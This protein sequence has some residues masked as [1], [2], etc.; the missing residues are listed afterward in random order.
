M[1]NFLL[2]YQNLQTNKLENKKIIYFLNNNLHFSLSFEEGEKLSEK[3]KD[4]EVCLSFLMSKKQAVLNLNEM[5]K[6][7]QDKSKHLFYLQV[8]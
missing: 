4:E 6:R 1:K 2:C 5:V 3:Y 7:Y 8:E